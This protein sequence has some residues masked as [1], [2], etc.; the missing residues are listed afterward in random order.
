MTLNEN[1]S[2]LGYDAVQFGKELPAFLEELVAS[3]TLDI[4]R[5][6][7]FKEPAIIYQ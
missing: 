6:I 4:Y 7:S 5:A 3:W 1:P 2:L